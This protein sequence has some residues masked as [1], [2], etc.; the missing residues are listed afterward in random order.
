M[1]NPEI[2]NLKS[3]ILHQGRFIY[4][5]VSFD[6]ES[7]KHKKQKLTRLVFDRGNGTAILLYNLEKQSV[8]LISQFRLP[9]L[10]N[11]HPTGMLIEACAGTLEETNPEDCIRREAE[12]ETGYRIGKVEKIMEV[13]M[14]PGAMT[15]K[16]F[17]FSAPYEPGMKVSDGGGLEEEHEDI[18]VLEIPFHKAIEMMKK[19]EIEDAKS[20]LL[21]QHAQLHIFNK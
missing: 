3:E 16:L 11:H 7:I 8:I 4:K 19:G 15:E 9:A 18:E 1:K 12:E 5:Q 13:F 17:L 6:Y 10:L 2:S 14:S 20:V 21:L